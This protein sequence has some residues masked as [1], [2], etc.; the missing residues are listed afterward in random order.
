MRQLSTEIAHLFPQTPRHGLPDPQAVSNTMSPTIASLDGKHEL[1][2]RTPRV[3]NNSTIPA[4]VVS[5]LFKDGTVIQTLP[6]DHLQYEQSATQQM[7]PSEDVVSSPRSNASALLEQAKA[8]ESA[9]HRQGTVQR[10]GT[11]QRQGTVQRQSTKQ[12]DK[13]SQITSLFS[14]VKVLRGPTTADVEEDAVLFH[15]DAINFLPHHHHHL[16]AEMHKRWTEAETKK[17]PPKVPP[18]GESGSNSGT[19]RLSRRQTLGETGSDS[20]GSSRSSSR[21]ST[22]GKLSRQSSRSKLNR[23]TSGVSRMDR[24]QATL[25]KSQVIYAPD[26]MIIVCFNCNNSCDCF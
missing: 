8:A 17:K 14:L 1:S 13:R 24:L 21:P 5:P 9:A 22:A 6:L 25:R 23:Q 15:D 26:R 16:D 4:L 7:M 12:V 3:S 20:E 19:P 18:P 2:L 11:L 10:Q